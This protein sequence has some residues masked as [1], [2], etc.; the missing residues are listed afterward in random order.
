MPMMTIKARIHCDPQTESTLKDAMLSATKVYNG[1][2]WHLRKEYEKTGKSTVTR[3][4]LNLILKKLPRT[5]NYYSMSEQLTRDEV[6]Q[7]YKSF[8]E[9]KKKGLTHHHAPGFRKKKVLSPLKYVQGG[10]KVQGNKVTLSLGT[11]RQDGVKSVS[12]RISHRPDLHYEKVRQISVVYDKISGQLE[13]RLTVERKLGPSQGSGQVAI[14]LGET[15]MMTCAFD[16]GTVS[17]YSGRKIKSIR[18]YWHKVRANLKQGSRRWFQI[19]H[20]ERKQ[21]DQLLHGATSHFISECVKKGI[22][23][24]AIGDLKGI[25]ENMDSS[26]S[27][28]Q[29]LH[30]WPYRKIIHML[31]Y[32]GQLAGMEVYDNIDEKNTSGTCHGCG[33]IL[34]SNR[35]HRGMYLCSCGWKVQADINGALNI[36]EKAYKVSPIKGSSGRVAR[37]VA[38]SYHPGWHGVTEPKCS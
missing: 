6:I 17:L 3:K 32:K 24:V 35:K 9:L 5:K 8:F 34:P 7:S 23:E 27:V 33:K 29:R 36:F 11:S 26:D 30:N 10:F 19:A 28:N 2:L 37:P 31:K 21:V 15:M 4:N 13:A 25:R 14:D 38:M 12:F 18:R 16:D 22:R 20:K 1:L